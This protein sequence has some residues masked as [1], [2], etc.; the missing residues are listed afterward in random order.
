LIEFHVSDGDAAVFCATEN[1]K[2]PTA[3]ALLYR[4]LPNREDASLFESV[5]MG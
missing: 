3:K 2:A 1:G 5:S 4:A